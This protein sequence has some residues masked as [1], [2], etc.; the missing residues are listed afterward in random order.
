MG[1]GERKHSIGSVAL[2]LGASMIWGVSFVAQSAGMEHIG[3]F[4]FTAVRSAI[5]AIGLGLCALLF[6]RIGLSPK[7]GD[8]KRLWTGGVLL[9]VVLFV[10]G[11][12]QQIGLQYTSVGKAGFIT[13]L[14]IVFVPIFGLFIGRRAHPMLWACALLASVG[15]YF[16]SIREDFTIGAGDLLVL[17]CAVVYA[18]HI[19][20]IDH[21]AGGVDA[22]RLNCIQFAVTGLLSAVPAI[23]ERPTVP[24]ITQAWLPLLYAGLLAGCCS[25]TM[26][27]LAQRSVE[28]TTASLLLSP[29]A[30]FAALAGW[31]LLGQTLS[32]RELLG[33]TLVF[34]AVVSSQ[35]PWRRILG[36]RAREAAQAIEAQSPEA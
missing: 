32:S 17:A 27:V 5:A 8:P 11:N 18:V 24:A 10:G 14:Y 25:Y 26:Q 21:F 31:A 7:G 6:D 12:L 15:L 4:T 29:E 22:V 30:V 2:L 9:G 20:L 19:L 35:L 1:D 34:I 33:C 28:P 3:P 16:L 36:G 13:S 23:W